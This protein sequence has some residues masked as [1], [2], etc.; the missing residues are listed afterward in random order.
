VAVS[1]GRR[2]TAPTAHGGAR[3]S[4]PEAT[5]PGRPDPAPSARLDDLC[6]LYHQ[7]LALRRAS[8]RPARGPR[9]GPI[10]RLACRIL[11]TPTTRASMARR[12]S[13]AAALRHSRAPDEALHATRPAPDPTSTRITSSSVS[14][15][16]PLR[17]GPPGGR[18]EAGGE[19]RE[20][21][22]GRR[23]AGLDAVSE[24]N[25]LRKRAFSRGRAR[26]PST[27]LV[28]GTTRTSRT[29]R[30]L[31]ERSGRVKARLDT[32]FSSTTYIHPPPR[33]TRSTPTSG[34]RV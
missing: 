15:C 32:R 24:G 4:N 23:E 30:A 3:C 27:P 8:H 26:R 17:S 33:L 20:A 25:P 6:W 1:A 13:R 28:Q 11:Q 18:R 31:P 5:G 2:P 22:G 19:R 9:R 16:P 12:R 34:S 14:A 21:G 7:H 10:L 29:P